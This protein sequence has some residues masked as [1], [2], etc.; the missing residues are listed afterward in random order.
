MVLQEDV[1]I[2]SMLRPDTDLL[3]LPEQYFL[4]ID[5]KIVELRYIVEDTNVDVLSMFIKPRMSKKSICLQKNLTG[6]EKPI[7]SH[8]ELPLTI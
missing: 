2:N 3:L 7:R 1:F 6:T 8:R 4:S 5:P